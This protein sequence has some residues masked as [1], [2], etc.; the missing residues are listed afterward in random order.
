MRWDRY[1]A[2]CARCPCKSLE[3]FRESAACQADQNSSLSGPHVLR[4]PFT[5][6]DIGLNSHQSTVVNSANEMWQP[7]PGGRKIWFPLLLAR[8]G[9]T[10]RQLEERV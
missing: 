6:M 1:L 9:C 2:S 7:T 10:V 8:R 3:T 5:Y 4:H